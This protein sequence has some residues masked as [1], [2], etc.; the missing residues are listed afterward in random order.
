MIVSEPTLFDAT[1][2]RNNVYRQIQ[3]HLSEIR[4]KVLIAL[5]EIGNGTDNDI[6]E[7]LGW[8]INRVTGRRFELQ[9]LKFVDAIGQEA[10]PYRCPRTIWKVNELQLN[11]FLSQSATMTPARL[12]SGGADK[13]SKGN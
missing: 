11:Y 9:Q 7:H 1:Q 5:F 2:N 4:A 12:R 13:Q 6:A 3:E 8:T 10:G